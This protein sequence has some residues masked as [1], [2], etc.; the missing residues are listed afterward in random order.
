MRAILKK[1]K[2]DKPCYTDNGSI[3][4]VVEG[5][6]ICSVKKDGRWEWTHYELFETQEGEFTGIGGIVYGKKIG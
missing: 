1:G 2:L 4:I 3:S 6:T 5:K